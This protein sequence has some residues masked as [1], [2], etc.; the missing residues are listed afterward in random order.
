MLQT[1]SHQ[2]FSGCHLEKIMPCEFVSTEDAN[3]GAERK[4]SAVQLS[5]ICVQ[6]KRNPPPGSVSAQEQYTWA[7]HA[8]V[9]YANLS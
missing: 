7:H 8:G 9:R 4:Q 6:L 2:R 5:T 3:F 1:L